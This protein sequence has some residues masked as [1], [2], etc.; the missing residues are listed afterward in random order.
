M[1]VSTALVARTARALEGRLSRRSLINRS[2]FVGSAV[3]VGSGLDLALKP[4]TAYG[5][6]CECRE[7]R[8][9]LQQH[10]LR[11]ILRVL[12]RGERR[13]LVSREHR[14]GRLVDGG[15]LVL[16][17]RPTV[18]HGLQFHLR[19]RERLRQRLL[20]LRDGLRPDRVRLWPAGVQL[21]RDRLLPVPLRAVQP[22]RRLPGPDRLP[23]LACGPRWT[24]GSLGA[25]PP[26]AVDNSTA[27]QNEPCWT[28]APPA[29]PPPPCLSPATNCQVVGA[30]G[31]AD[32]GGYAVFTLF[33]GLF[34]FG[35]FPNDGDASGATLR[36]SDRRRGDLCDL[37]ATSW[38]RPT[39][40][41]SPTAGPLFG[42]TGGQRLNASGGRDGGLAVR[43]RLRARRC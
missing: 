18:L 40:A 16:L 15:Q 30:L 14:D 37:G 20:V 12:L 21:L 7:Y 23:G 28:T 24:G 9:R 36:R 2:A 27:E 1:S 29:L 38:S 25:R 10:V 13:Q 6:I 31:S 4:G 35:D 8:L 43:P 41:S 33:A 32:G 3:A 11:G 19:L 17:R 39:A 34:D 42:S 26:S 5:A 22:E